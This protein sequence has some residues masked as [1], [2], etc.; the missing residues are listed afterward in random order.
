MQNHE[1]IDCRKIQEEVCEELTGCMYCPGTPTAP[2]RPDAAAAL[3]AAP[4]PDEDRRFDLCLLLRPAGR[5]SGCCSCS[6]GSIIG[7]ACSSSLLSCYQYKA[8]LLYRND[9]TV[10]VTYTDMFF[11]HKIPLWHL[12]DSSTSTV[13]TII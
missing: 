4:A 7:A 1:K 3:A 13:Y 12:E 10:C 9:V 8:R 11:M 6:F 2:T 5:N